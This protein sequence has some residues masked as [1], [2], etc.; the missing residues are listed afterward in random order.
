MG[1]T[2]DQTG[3]AARAPVPHRRRWAAVALVGT[4]LVAGAGCGP[5]R[6][7]A[8]SEPARSEPDVRAA[9]HTVWAALQSADPGPLLAAFTD[10]VQLHSPALI[11]PEYRGRAVVA[12]I[13]TAAVRVLGAARVTDVLTA[14]DGTTGSVVFETR[15]ENEPAQG[16]VLLRTRAAQVSEITLLLRP[17]PALRAFVAQM[18]ALGAKPALDAG[19]G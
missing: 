3:D 2:S 13:V 1:S 11:G 8:S 7:H 18:G 14:G 17:F 15:I 10:D 6:S 9:L 19:P 12:P 16:V 5:Y 4:V